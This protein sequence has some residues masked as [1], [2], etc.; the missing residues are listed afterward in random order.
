MKIDLPKLQE[1]VTKDLQT[2]LKAPSMA[3]AFQQPNFQTVVEKQLNVLAYLEKTNGSKETK[4]NELLQSYNQLSGKHF[5]IDQ[6]ISFIDHETLVDDVNY[7]GIYIRNIYKIDLAMLAA[8]KQAN[9][10][11]PTVSEAAPKSAG[12]A[13]PFALPGMDNLP[14]GQNP[15][16]VAMA[17]ARIHQEFLQG[18][19][20][21]FKTKPKV[22]PLIK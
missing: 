7:L 9:I 22:I 6:N 5:T 21:I 19:I 3:N 2:I 12:G 17:S 16:S 14:P 18:K 8:G 15:M 11:S 10:T 20:Y 1:K 4:V 13:T